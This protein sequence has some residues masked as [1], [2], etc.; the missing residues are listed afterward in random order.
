[1]IVFLYYSDL[2]FKKGDLIVLLK[3]IDANWFFG[4]LN[5][6][7]GFLPASYIQ[8]IDLPL[9][10][11][12][13]IALH[14]FRVTDVEEKDCISFVKGD[15]INVIR[16]VDDNWAEGKLGDRIGIFPIKF[17]DMNPSARNLMKLPSNNT[18]PSRIA[19][20]APVNTISLIDINISN[21][22]LTSSTSNVQSNSVVTNTS[23]QSIVTNSILPSS[24]SINMPPSLSVLSK[25]A[26]NSLPTSSLSNVTFATGTISSQANMLAESP[27][28]L[29]GQILSSQKR[30]S[31]CGSSTSS[32]VS[33]FQRSISYQQGNSN[34]ETQ[35]SYRHSMEILNVDQE[36][37]RPIMTNQL[38]ESGMP[39]TSSNANSVSH[40]SS[41]SQ[42]L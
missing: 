34:S 20:P 32:L 25:N 24:S 39:S 38:Y 13:C 9:L 7:Q 33:Q 10:Q 21:S 17:V 14:D 31:L 8:V 28:A 35:Q 19:P 27:N 5:G 29:T 30:H 41:T 22:E 26:N 16:R 23:S 6:K 36:Q 4:E 18:G 40:P 11:P 12:Q 37:S 1:M 2:S 15:V 42:T 3:K